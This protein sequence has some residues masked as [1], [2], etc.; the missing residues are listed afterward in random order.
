MTYH[1]NPTERLYEELMAGAKC[2][3]CGESRR[4]TLEWHHLDPKKKHRAISSLVRSG[5][6]WSLVRAELDN[7]ILVC[8]NC[9]RMLEYQK[10]L[11]R[12]SVGM[13]QLSIP[14]EMT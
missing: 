1:P 13:V 14:E 6:R 3:I 11:E 8:A 9:H 4:P 5:S 7:C 12:R 2:S 10:R